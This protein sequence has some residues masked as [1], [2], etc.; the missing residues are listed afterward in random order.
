[1]TEKRF[2]MADGTYPQ[3]V[4]FDGDKGLSYFD[5]IELLN[6]QHEENEQLKKEIKDL[7]NVNVLKDEYIRGIRE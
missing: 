6:A 5:M 1:M 7:I 2:R 4:V 3:T